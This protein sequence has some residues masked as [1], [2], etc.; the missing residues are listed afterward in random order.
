[1]ATWPVVLWARWW[2]GADTLWAPPTVSDQAGVSW[3][4]PTRCQGWAAHWRPKSRQATPKSILG[5]LRPHWPT[6]VSYSV[7][8]PL[9]CGLPGNSASP[10]GQGSKKAQPRRPSLGVGLVGAVRRVSPPR[11]MGRW[12]RLRPGRP[13]WAA[14]PP[15]PWGRHGSGASP[16]DPGAP[17]ASRWTPAQA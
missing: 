17:C 1:M 8:S 7:P 11:P 6:R 12:L 10:P 13:W 3:A 5:V 14:C 16:G 15:F 9:P 2:H 4:P